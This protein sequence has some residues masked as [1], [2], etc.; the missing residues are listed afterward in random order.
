MTYLGGAQSKA[1]PDTQIL[2]GICKID[3][4]G[5]SA[6]KFSSGATENVFI[7]SSAT[8]SL[9]CAAQGAPKPSF[10]Y[11]LTVSFPLEPVGGSKPKFLDDD[12]K[13]TV[14]SLQSVVNL[15]CQAQGHPVPGFR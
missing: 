13:N 3:P 1:Y 9:T 14:A 2:Y 15:M 10:R 6:P 12:T 4:V 11:Y 7:S 5:G 8:V